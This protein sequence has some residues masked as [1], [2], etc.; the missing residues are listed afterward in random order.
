MTKTSLF[1]NWKIP[2]GRQ[3]NLFGACDLVLITVTFKADEQFIGEIAR[4]K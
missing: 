2:A 1:G 4:G 3:G